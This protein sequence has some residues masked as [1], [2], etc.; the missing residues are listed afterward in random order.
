MP[1]HILSI[2][3]APRHQLCKY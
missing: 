1:D 2:S 3:L